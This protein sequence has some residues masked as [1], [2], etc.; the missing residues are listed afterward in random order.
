MTH[1][2][3][4]GSVTISQLRAWAARPGHLWPCSELAEVSY[5]FAAFDTNGLVDLLGDDSI[6]LSGDELSAWSSDVIGAV[7]PADHPC[8]LVTV[9]QFRDEPTVCAGTGNH[10]GQGIEDCDECNPAKYE[11]MS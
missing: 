6:E 3:E 8:Y 11:S 7:L 4:Y 1:T 10:A 9:G 5:V 2:T